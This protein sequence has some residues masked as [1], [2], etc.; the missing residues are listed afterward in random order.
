M[1]NDEILN[2]YKFAKDRNKEIFILSDLTLKSIKDIV[3]IIKSAG[4]P[5]D[6]KFD[7]YK[8]TRWTEELDNRLIELRNKN[9]TFEQIGIIMGLSKSATHNRYKKLKIR[10]VVN[11]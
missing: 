8:N 6:T 7:R 1:S 3:S 10:G 2:L 9:L 4:Y 5:V 11:V